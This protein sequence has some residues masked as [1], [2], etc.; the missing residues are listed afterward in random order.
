MQRWVAF[1]ISYLFPIRFRLRFGID[2]ELHRPGHG[3]EK[4]P[5]RPTRQ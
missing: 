2:L 5:H 3:K 4:E 1:A